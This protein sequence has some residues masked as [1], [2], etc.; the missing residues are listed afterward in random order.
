MYTFHIVYVVLYFLARTKKRMLLDNSLRM[1]M[2]KQTQWKA[3][4][5]KPTWTSVSQSTVALQSF[6]SNTPIS[7]NTEPVPKKSITMRSLI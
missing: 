5:Q 3:L 7:P 1:G 6:F 2:H 4:W